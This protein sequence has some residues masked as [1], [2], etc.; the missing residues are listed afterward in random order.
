[1]KIL[2]NSMFVGNYGLDK[3]NLPHEV[4]NFFRADNGQFYV[5][6]TPYGTISPNMD[7]EDLKAILFVHNVGNGLIE[8]V[9]KAELDESSTL[10]TQG[11]EVRLTDGSIK[12]KKKKEKYIADMAKENIQ[13]GGITIQDIHSKNNVDNEIHV[14]MKAKTIC[15]PQNPLFLTSKEELEDM[16]QRIFYISPKKISNQSMKAYYDE[17]S[18]TATGYKKLLD[19]IE[20][21]QIWLSPDYVPNLREADITNDETSNNFFRII[22]QQN[23]ELIFSNMF[24]YLF[25]QY[26]GL[27]QKFASD[28]L[29]TE[30]SENYIIDRE[31]HHMDLR[32]VDERN[33]IIIENKIKS[34][35][36]GTEKE[37]GELKKEA[38][39][40]LASQLSKYYKIAEEEKGK[41]KIKAFLFMPDYSPIDISKYSCGD[42]YKIIRYKQIY[43]FFTAC[44]NNS[45][46]PGANDP[47]LSEFIKALH[48]HTDNTDNEYRNELMNRLKNRIEECKFNG[49]INY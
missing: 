45:D 33:Y 20:N 39:G 10:F 17:N 42:K 46:N 49:K 34:L 28:I 25:S 48:K 19:I 23:N 1:M 30:L 36:N 6:I 47:Y 35:I 9:A 4:I 7:I 3:G 27:L 13:Y 37:S 29:D 2:L 43:D 15:F 8:V 38:D 44:M 24:Y 21:E 32:L 16:E 5:Y 14:T 26:P 22:G 11:I 41:R 18:D 31:K 40:K 12:N